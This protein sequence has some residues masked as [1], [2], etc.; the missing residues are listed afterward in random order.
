[1]H[2]ARVSELQAVVAWK[3]TFT[4][5]QQDEIARLSLQ[6]QQERAEAD[7]VLQRLQ[8]KSQP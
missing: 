7:G 4:Q 8:R 3:D 2:S 1:L 6:L 5:R